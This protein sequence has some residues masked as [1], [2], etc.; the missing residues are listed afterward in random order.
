MS[1]S[2]IIREALQALVRNRIRSVLTM[3]GIV[4]GVGSFICVVAVGNAGSSR[5]EDQLSKVGDNL[6]W[7]EAGSRAVNGVR[8]GSRGTRTL[9][10]GD[11]QAVLDQVPG[12]KSGTPNVDGH[13][14][15]VYGNLNWGTQYRGVSPEFFEIRKWEFRLGGNFTQDDVERNAPVCVL[16]QTVA[17]SLF[18]DDDPLGKTIN[19]QAVPFKVIGVLQGRGFSATGQDQ[20]DFV[21][22]PITT[23]QKRITGQEWL[24][25]IFFAASSREEI[26]EATRQIIGVMRERHH[27]RA[28][29]LDDFNIRTPEQLI[30][31][32]LAA[33]NVFTLLL[34]SAASLSLLVG[35]IGIM[36]IML[37]SVTERTREIG[38]R[39]AVGATEQDIQMQFLSEAMVMSLMGGALGVLAGVLGSFLLQSTLHWEMQLSAQIM[40]IAGLFSAGVGIFFGYY[41][42]RKA[43]QLDPIEG[44]RYE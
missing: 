24:D 22:M 32:Q 1:L 10:E 14:Q 33:A 8:I 12:V 30:R 23:A 27:L 40:V 13:I 26:P 7:V 38:I 6:I 2:T 5:V 15:V 3:L 29:D 39:L 9:V 17:T 19:I 34:G 42:A 41:P 4:M 20:D 25:D 37:V 16:G 43:A 18:G 11:V 21:V 28:G 36:N 31:A 35:G 44:L